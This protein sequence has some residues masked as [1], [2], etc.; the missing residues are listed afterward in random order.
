MSDAA[1]DAG[2][3]VTSTALS[4]VSAIA[5]IVSAIGSIIGIIQNIHT[6]NI[7]GEIEQNT[8]YDY[9]LNTQT[10]QNIQWPEFENSGYMVATLDNMLIDSNTELATIQ[11][12]LPLLGDVIAWLGI[13]ADVQDTDS[14]IRTGRIG[15]SCMAAPAS[16]GYR[17]NH[18][19]LW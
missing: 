9:I 6:D 11:P 17:R 10:Q 1:S 3:A 18:G 12:Y 15:K 14:A 4:T 8:R 19:Y 13:D 16:S 5:S 7:L 2:D